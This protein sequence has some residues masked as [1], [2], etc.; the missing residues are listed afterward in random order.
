[1]IFGS[2][3]SRY[4]FGRLPNRKVKTVLSTNFVIKLIKSSG[5][6]SNQVKI[7]FI[8]SQSRQALY[9]IQLIKNAYVKQMKLKNTTTFRTKNQ[10][11]YFTKDMT[12]SSS[13]VE[14]C[15]ES[16]KW[17]RVTKNTEGETV[18]HK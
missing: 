6:K 10:L 17:A 5:I 9:R 1:M 18:C 15:T 4:N 7:V 12:F 16:L 8:S 2:G 3:Y 11:Q 13:G 14:K